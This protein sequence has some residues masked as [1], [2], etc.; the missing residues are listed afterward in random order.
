MTKTQHPLYLLAPAMLLIGVLYLAPNLLNFALAFTDWNSFRSGVSFVG[1][2]NFTEQGSELT[3][4]LVTTFVFAIVSTVLMNTIA[5]SFALA[6]E[7]PGRFATVFS[8]LLFFPILL[9]PLAAGYTFRALLQQSGPIDAVLQWFAGGPG[10]IDW[11]GGRYTALAAVILTHCWRFYALHMLIYVAALRSIPRELL[12]AARTEG[13]S[14]WAAFWNIKMPLV[15]P[16]M[17]FNVSIVFI[18]SLS[19][20]D[21]VL[22]MTRG[23]PARATEVLNVYVWRQ[24]ST[25]ALGFSTAISLVLLVAILVTGLPL[26]ALLRRREID[27]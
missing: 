23:G 20:F 27:A 8:T 6:L 7:R 18:A 21:T 17:T 25:G 4:A 12:E 3:D 9:S 13:A 15:A 11:L 1:I 24:F 16:A 2:D 5:M 22:A 14:A 26:I 10:R 19:A